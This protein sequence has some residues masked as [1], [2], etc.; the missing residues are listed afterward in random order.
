MENNLINK[1]DLYKGAE[2]I[3]DYNSQDNKDIIK[4]FC[5]RIFKYLH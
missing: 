4:Y 3:V 1:Y 5:I 2:V